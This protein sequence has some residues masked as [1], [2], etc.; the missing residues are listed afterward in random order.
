MHN[1]NNP[2]SATMRQLTSSPGAEVK[3][4]DSSRS[5]AVTKIDGN[6]NAAVKRAIALVGGMESG[7]SE[8]DEVYLKPNFVAPRSS[9]N[10]VTTN[11][12]VIQ[13]VAEEVRRCGASPVLFETPAVEF[14]REKVYKILGVR[15]FA[16][17]HGIRIAEDA[18]DL[19]TVP[20]PGGNVLKRI[21]IPARL[22]TAKI[23]NIPKLKTHVSAR[24][25][26]AMKNLIGLLPDCE[27]RRVH[28][29]G[30]H[31]AIADICK[32]I[33]PVLTVVDAGTC[34]QGD[35]P[36]YGDAIE[37]GLILAGRDMVSVDLACSRAIGIP[38]GE[39]PRYIRLAANGRTESELEMVGDPLGGLAQPFRIPEKSPIFHALFRG[40]YITDIFWSR[41]S[42]VPLN[43]YLY[44]T[45]LIGTNPRILEQKCNLCGDCVS[46]CPEPRAIRLE[47]FRIDYQVCIRCLN[48][49]GVCRQEAIVVRGVSRPQQH[50]AGS[51]SSA[52]VCEPT[53]TADLNRQV[54][55]SRPA[56]RKSIS[57]FFP[58]LNEEGSVERLTRDLLTILR[59]EFEQGEVII[60]DDGSTDRTGE[61]ADRLARENEGWVR[62]IHHKASRG[63]GNA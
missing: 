31:E 32:V 41:F 49:H 48:C 23:I 15:E 25:T 62:V 8:G 51:G 3:S 12:E 43:S 13:A 44:R 39:I 27:K 63:Y 2:P 22:R 11:L 59:Q 42:K 30:V 52:A 14:D 55:E 1:P 35:G 57:V 16:G 9:S 36:T 20:V 37:R 18:G 56:L 28:V 34:M 45:G 10:G 61:I 60:V 6:I 21:K 38:P 47:Q 46:S 58:C 40:I 17:D 7:V 19:V 33:Q 50:Q 54:Q 5:V 29:R 4:R 26:C 53:G 24:M